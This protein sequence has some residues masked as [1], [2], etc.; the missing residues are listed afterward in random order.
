MIPV[1]ILIEEAITGGGIF[2]CRQ[3]GNGRRKAVDMAEG[4]VAGESKAGLRGRRP[5]L[6]MVGQD[7]PRHGRRR[8]HSFGEPLIGI[9]QRGQELFRVLRSDAVLRHQRQ[10]Q[11]GRSTVR[12]RKIDI[13]RDDRC[14]G[15]A[16]LVDQLRHERAGPWPL[17]D[18]SEAVVVDLDNA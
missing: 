3:I 1:G 17:A 2:Q 5:G 18:L 6:A 15:L 8:A 7:E 16:Q 14:A 9:R 12:L 4:I 10:K 11:F 13:E